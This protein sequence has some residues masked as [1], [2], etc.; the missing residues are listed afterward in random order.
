MLG[1]LGLNK[2]HKCVVRYVNI[3]EYPEYPIV[4]SILLQYPIP[5]VNSF[6]F[7]AH[8]SPIPDVN[9]FSF[10]AHESPIPDV[11]SFS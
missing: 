6:S 7:V 4:N 10:V 9:S 3:R 8:E 1:Y 2:P 11:N 5:D